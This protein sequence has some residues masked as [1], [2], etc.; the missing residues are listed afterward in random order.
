MISVPFAA[1]RWDMSLFLRATGSRKVAESIWAV[2]LFCWTWAL[3]I[4]APRTSN[5]F[6]GTNLCSLASLFFWIRGTLLKKRVAQFLG[7]AAPG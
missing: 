1:A 7:P 4:R 3:A 6:R 5:I 2:L